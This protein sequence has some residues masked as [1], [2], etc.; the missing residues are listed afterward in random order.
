MVIK[1]FLLPLHPEKSGSCFPASRAPRIVSMRSWGAA[2]AGSVRILARPTAKSCL[3]GLRGGR[4]CVGERLVGWRLR[5]RLAAAPLG[6]ICGCYDRRRVAGLASLAAQSALLL[7]SMAIRAGLPFR[8]VTLCTHHTRRHCSASS[9]CP[10]QGRH[11]WA[12]A[13]STTSSCSS[14]LIS[15]C[16]S[17]GVA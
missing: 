5:R 6:G 2:P 9:L 17:H 11:P 3:R 10:A 8:S 16:R 4:G 12:V 1:R 14:S 13:L 7:H 15:A